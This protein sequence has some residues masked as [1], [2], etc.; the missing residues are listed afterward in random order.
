MT[1]SHDLF[2]A[3]QRH[4]PG[5]VNS[6]VRA[7]RGVGGDPVFFERGEGPY[8][9][10]CRRQALYRLRRLLGADDP[11]PRPSRGGRG[12]AASGST[13]GCRSAPRPSIETAHGR[14][15]SANW[16]RPSS[17][18]R[19]VSSGTEAT[20]SAIRLARGYHRARQD[21]QIRRL[22][23]RPRRLAAGQGRLR[24]ADLRRAQ[25]ARRAGG[26]G[27]AHHHPR[28]TTTSSRCARPFAEHRRR[29]RLHHRRAGGRQHELHPAA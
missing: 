25:L 17:M 4:I 6:P 28:A 20:M 19:M 3:A 8:A 13:R 2:A 10:R 29:D 21:R 23:S 1:R 5:G 12:G 15:R 14:D 18:V 26:A 24:R 7:F 11:G 9:L 27:R 16:C 22:L